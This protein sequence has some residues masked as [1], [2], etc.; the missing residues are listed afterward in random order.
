MF[1]SFMSTMQM[2]NCIFAFLVYNISTKFIT[3]FKNQRKQSIAVFGE[4][5]IRL[6]DITK[7]IMIGIV[8]TNC[9]CSP[10]VYSYSAFPAI[11]DRKPDS[12]VPEGTLWKFM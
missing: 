2:T 11:Q 3:S 12:S 9:M 8:V 7:K 10:L 5:F 4:S 6:F 1:V